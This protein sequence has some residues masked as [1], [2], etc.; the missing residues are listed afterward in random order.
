MKCKPGYEYQLTEDLTIQTSMHGFNITTDW[1][2]LTPD[3][4][5]TLKKGYAWDGATSFPDIKSIMTGSAIHDAFYQLMRMGLI[6]RT[7]RRLIDQNFVEICAKR[8]MMEITQAVVFNGVR[9]FAS[10]AASAQ[11]LKKELVFP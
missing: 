9:A 2:R 4:E 5:M 7:F 1:I 3:G 11:N 8:G 10:D 6:P